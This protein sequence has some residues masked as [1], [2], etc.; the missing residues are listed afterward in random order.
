MIYK[1]FFVALSFC[2]ITGLLYP[3]LLSDP[4]NNQQNPGYTKILIKNDDRKLNC[5][6]FQPRDSSI[7]T[8]IILIHEEWGLTD[9]IIRISSEIAEQGYLVIVPDLVS[10]LVSGKDTVTDLS[11]EEI[12]RTQLLNSGHEAIKIALDESFKYLKADP[13]C[14]GKIA[15]IGFSWGGTQAFMYMTENENLAA[16]FIFYGRSP[17]S[18]RD[19]SRIKAP[20]YGIYGEYD[21]M[22]NGTLDATIRRMKRLGKD[23]QPFIINGGGHGFMRSG[24]RPGATED[25]TKARTAGWNKLLELISLL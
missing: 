3:Q 7:S 9:W 5:L 10:S 14:N 16:G 1:T 15:V 11:N 12:I 21:T 8:G 23:Y 6:V 22:L 18:N 13:L 17:E 19:L 24:E 2:S 4:L 25:N 20:V